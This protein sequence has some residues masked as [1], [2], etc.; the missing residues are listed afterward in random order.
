MKL[1]TDVEE[2][3][4]PPQGIYI[5]PF[6]IRIS[7]HALACGRTVGDE[8]HCVLSGGLSSNRSMWEYKT[9]VLF[10]GIHSALKP[11][12]SEE[13]K[14]VA[15]VNVEM[16]SALPLHPDDPKALK[17]SSTGAIS[18]PLRLDMLPSA[19]ICAAVKEAL[20]PLELYRTNKCKVNSN[21][22]LCLSRK[23]VKIIPQRIKGCRA[24]K[25]CVDCWP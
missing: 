8:R 18:N 7:L 15:E 20:Y 10:L 5:W 16:L 6:Q 2:F 9:A 1:L 22:Y 12:W 24:Q 4:P 25:L 11:R 17:K 3:F 13:D 23:K 19:A 14:L 21:K